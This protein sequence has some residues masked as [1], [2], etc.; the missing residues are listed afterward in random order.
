MR[1]AL[2]TPWT[3]AAHFFQSMHH[4]R[5]SKPSSLAAASSSKNILAQSAA[6]T[7]TS[8]KAVAAVAIDVPL[9]IVG[10]FLGI[11]DGIWE[12]LGPSQPTKPRRHSRPEWR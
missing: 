11:L 12:D 6:Q 10:V 1:T 3:L 2:L 4:R 5:Q 9:F 7:L 8:L